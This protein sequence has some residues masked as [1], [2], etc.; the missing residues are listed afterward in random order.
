MIAL[1]K[2]LRVLDIVWFLNPL[3]SCRAWGGK[4]NKLKF[5]KLSLTEVKSHLTAFM[6]R[7]LVFTRPSST[8]VTIDYHNNTSWCV[9]VYE[10]QTEGSGCELPMS[11]Q[12]LLSLL[13]VNGFQLGFAGVNMIACCLPFLASFHESQ[14]CM[15]SSGW[16]LDTANSSASP[17]VFT[18]LKDMGCE[19]RS[20]LTTVLSMIVL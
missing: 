1:K 2:T 9:S 6:L 7:C 16:L 20:L 4:E 17:F 19:M 3:E 5:E 14:L 10:E 11:P 13:I 18:L 15:S 8:S 12:P